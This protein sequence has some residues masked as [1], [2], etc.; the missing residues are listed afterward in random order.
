MQRRQFLKTLTTPVA[1]APVA[2]FSSGCG[3]LM[4]SER[5]GQP[6]T[7]QIDWKVAALNGLGMLFFFVPGV[8]AF[9]VD[10]YTGAIYLPYD[11]VHPPQYMPGP[12]TT[13]APSWSPSD[14]PGIA[15]E[16]LPS[17][18]PAVPAM[19]Q[20]STEV[21]GI[22]LRQVQ[23]PRDQINSRTLEYIV[24][25]HTGQSI[26]INDQD[27]RLSVLEKLEG[28]REQ[29]KRHEVDHGFGSTVHSFFTTPRNA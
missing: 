17:S 7:H 11:E 23:I 21:P 4:H 12:A 27:T 2:L 20:T 6:H 13:P 26:C 5:V 1:L 8:V 29:R 19:Q 3:S 22:E 15:T 24:S 16:G 10:F 25:S 18:P 14:S 9:A 28:F